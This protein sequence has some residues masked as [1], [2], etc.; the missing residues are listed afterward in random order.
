MAGAV[1]PY[2]FLQRAWQPGYP[3]G[4]SEWV[5][6]RMT[7]CMELDCLQGHETVAFPT[8]FT[9]ALGPTQLPI[10]LT[11]A[12]ISLRHG[13]EQ[14]PFSADVRNVWSCRPIHLLIWDRA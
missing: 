12:T 5:K 7:N 3:S 1:V 6:G 11:P 10:R 2:R 4:Y 9:L 13:A 14:S 8:T